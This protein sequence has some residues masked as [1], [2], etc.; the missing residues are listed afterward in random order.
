[1]GLARESTELRARAAE[2]QHAGP[3]PDAAIQ[4]GCPRSSSSCSAIWHGLDEDALSSGQPLIGESELAHAV[5]DVVELISSARSEDPDA[6]VEKIANENKRVRDAV[7]AFLGVLA[8][9]EAAA[10]I[11][12]DGHDLKLASEDIARA[13]QHVETVEVEEADE[14]ILGE[15]LGVLGG[16]RS[17]EHRRA[18]SAMIIRGRLAASLQP[19]DLLPRYGSTCIALVHRVTATRKD[20]RSRSTYVLRDLLEAG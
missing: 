13:V 19:G 14:Q 17:F 3:T 1:M 4:R 10:R 6:F 5:E 11:V 18:D 15:F 8:S 2:G 12:S 16:S 7:K 9:N 20:G